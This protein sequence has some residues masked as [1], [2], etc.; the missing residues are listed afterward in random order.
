MEPREMGTAGTMTHERARA[1]LQEAVDGRLSASQRR[2]LEQ[3]LATCA[4]CRAYQAELAS[5]EARLAS[6]L[7]SRWPDR[8]SAA[9]EHASLRGRTQ[10]RIRRQIM[11]K[12]VARTAAWASLA[13]LFVLFLAW[14]IRTSVPDFATLSTGT[15]E[16]LPSPTSTGTDADTIGA[17]RASIPLPTQATQGADTKTPNFRNGPMGAFPE[18][19]FVFS[20]APP[21]GPQRVMLFEQILPEALSA[22][23]ARQAAA[24]LG[25]VGEPL[26][27]HSE[28][29]E[30]TVYEVTDGY[31]LARFINFPQQFVLSRALGADPGSA[32]ASDD[33]RI[34]AA[35]ALIEQV[36][37][38]SLPYRAE[39]NLRG[40]VEFAP[41]LDERPVIFGIGDAAGGFGWARASVDAYGQV[42][43][44]YYSGREFREL[45]EYPVLSAERAWERLMESDLSQARFAVLGSLEAS[46]YRDWPRA[47]PTGQ[48]LDLYGYLHTAG[49]GNAQGQVWFNDWPVA[50]DGALSGA[51]MG[52]FLHLRGQFS[53]MDGRRVLNVESWELSPLEEEYVGGEV[54]RQ[55][56]QAFLM[57]DDG[58]VF[59]L[60]NFP[61]ELPDGTRI[62]LNGA[63]RPGNPVVLEW[64]LLASGQLRATYGMSM[65]C[66]GGG[67]GG[68]GEDQENANFGG[69]ALAALNL[70]GQDRPTPTPLPS[71]VIQVGQILEGV[72]GQLYLYQ[73]PVAEG[74]FALEGTLW[75]QPLVLA[76][77]EVP[78]GMLFYLEGPE[79]EGSQ[80][81]QNLPVKLW[82]RVERFKD[83]NPVVTVERLEALYPGLRIQAWAGVTE[84]VALEG[85][86]ALLL[87]TE[88]GERYLLKSSIGCGAACQIGVQADRVVY[89]G[90]ALPGETYAGYPLLVELGAGRLDDQ[91]D[92]SS[93]HMAS[94]EINVWNGITSGPGYN[95]EY[96]RGRVTIEK[97]EL[98]YLAISLDHCVNTPGAQ[99]ALQSWLY[100]Q[101]MWIFSGHFDDGRAFLVQ[102][103]ALPDEYLE[104]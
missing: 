61:Q 23:N 65:S 1:A 60:P 22:E 35:E 71:S 70:S 99:E 64:Q 76:G 11:L 49:A 52:E 69:G 81:Y 40:D 13:V 95:P 77:V 28:S 18:I 21:T 6:S 84:E 48:T 27:G 101:P 32:I 14:S 83:G 7:Q 103:Q 17:T 34:S 93:Y 38:R 2:L 57:N 104:N 16:N 73:R 67:G 96:L 78:E 15:P 20:V 46:D 59:L 47:Y 8:E 56:D 30:M 31:D 29:P 50:N 24:L 51:S 68:G 12:S 97:V 58:R 19:E 43:A 5:L 62:T 9:P 94:T 90:Y 72:E 3:H 87:T 86:Q 36:G 85:Q 4:E 39:I 80:P 45:G 98:A 63:A 42:S 79:L 74:Q 33:E 25:I 102:I 66:W 92:L 53:E 37:L 100:V 44:L 89:E 41:L 26:A 75:A 10:T 55:G 88:S 82:G 54:Q 91:Q